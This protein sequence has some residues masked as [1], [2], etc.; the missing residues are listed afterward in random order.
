MPPKK[1]RVIKAEMI[2]EGFAKV[3]IMKGSDG[4]LYLQFALE[5]D[6]TE[7]FACTFDGKELKEPEK[8]GKPRGQKRDR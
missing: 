6:K 5:D 1:R 8:K 4:K 7:L 3:S 2:Y